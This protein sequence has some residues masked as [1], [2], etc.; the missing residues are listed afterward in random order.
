MGPEKPR[1]SRVA[2]TQA[3]GLK[4]TGIQIMFLAANL[5]T[6]SVSADATCVALGENLQCVMGALWLR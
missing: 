1:V 2:Y 4:A 3:R 6:P 5:R